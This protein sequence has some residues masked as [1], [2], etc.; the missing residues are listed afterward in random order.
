VSAI[1][2]TGAAFT[3]G[4]F[5]AITITGNPL[6]PLVASVSLAPTLTEAHLGEPVSLT[7]AALDAGGNPF[8]GA[9]VCLL[10]AGRA[11]LEYYYPHSQPQRPVRSLCGVTDTQGKVTLFFTSKI[12]GTVG[13]VAAALQSGR[14]SVVSAPSHVI[15]WGHEREQGDYGR[16]EGWWR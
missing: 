4:S 1:L 2:Q 9:K 15:F 7:A 11:Q 6:T 5:N 10:S 8:A 13:V 14:G 16:R 12:T 3:K